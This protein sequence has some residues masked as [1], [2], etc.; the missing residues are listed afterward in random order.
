VTTHSD[1]AERA[2]AHAEASLLT[3]ADNDGLADGITTLEQY[4][5]AYEAVRTEMLDAYPELEGPMSG[6]LLG[7]AAGVCGRPSSVSC[8]RDGATARARH[9]PSGGAPRLLASQQAVLSRHARTVGLARG[10]HGQRRPSD[11]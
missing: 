1:A 7:E 6:D 9:P 8:S 4:R 3:Y 5:H 10:A 2:Y 11:Q